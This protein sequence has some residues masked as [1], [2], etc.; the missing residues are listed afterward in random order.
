MLTLGPVQVHSTSLVSGLLL[1]VIGVLFLRFDGTA[2][3]TGVLGFGDNTDLEV[4]L[5]QKAT[6]LVGAIP[7]WAVTG[8][9]A[10]VAAI[11][12]LRRA[13]SDTAS[14]AHDQSAS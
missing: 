5:Q 4:S 12:A 13:R 2:G 9:L 7:A 8:L 3:I 14:A 1:I 11:W 6:E 10:V